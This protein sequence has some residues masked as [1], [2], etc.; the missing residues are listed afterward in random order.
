MPRLSPPTRRAVASSAWGADRSYR[1]GWHEGLDFHD[2]AGE[3]VLAAAG[4]TVVRV[5]NTPDSFAGRWIA[6]DHGDG[7][8][9]RYLHNL[10]NDVTRGQRVSRGQRIGLVGDT[11]TTSAQPHVHFDIKASKA[12]AEAYVRKFGMPATG[13]GRQMSLG[14]GIPS[15][16]YMSG[17]TYTDKAKRQS[18]A[19]RVPLYQPPWLFYIAVAG[20]LY[21]LYREHG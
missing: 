4:G 9:S 16:P 3:P 21:W 13:L 17:V 7:I 2:D 19:A 18:L 15:E 8:V 1:G 11:G 10:R 6:I 20:G 14:I 5:D 12:A